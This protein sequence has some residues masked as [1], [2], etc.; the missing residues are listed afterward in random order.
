MKVIVFDLDDTLYDEMTY[1]KS[2]FQAVARFLSERFLIRYDDSMEIMLTE[3]ES[4]GRGQV[5]DRVLINYEIYSKNNVKDCLRVYRSHH[6]QIQLY[7]DAERC[8]KTLEQMEIPLYIVTDGNKLV[9]YRK[10][11]TLGLYDHPAIRKCYISRRFGTK[12]EKPSPYCFMQICTKEQ[13]KPSDVVY[14][15]DNPNKDFVGIKPLGFKT[16]RVLRGGFVD[17]QKPQ[18]F[19]ADIAVDSLDE[20]LAHLIGS[21]EGDA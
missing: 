6:P 13:V 17:I 7:D 11:K 4:N 21:G 5:F 16:V 2:G 15:G 20:V 14:V 1:V 12:H 8:I 10:L 3:L 9:Q 18:N 19:E